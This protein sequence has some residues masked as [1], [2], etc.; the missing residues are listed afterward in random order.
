MRGDLW[1]KWGALL[2]LL[3]L[4]DAARELAVLEQRIERLESAV[5]ETPQTDGQKITTDAGGGR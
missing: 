5:L 4:A 3:E 2:P 1:A